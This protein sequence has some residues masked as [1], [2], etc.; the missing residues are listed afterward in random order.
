MSTPPA[1]TV[2]VA[3]VSSDTNVLKPSQATVQFFQGQTN[4]SVSFQG[5]AAGRVTV[6][7]TDPTGLYTPDTLIMGVLSTLEFRTIQSPTIRATN[8]S[9]NSAE[10]RSILVIL[11]DPAPPAGLAV[12]FQS[13]TAG[14]AA[15][16][17]ATAT[18]PGGQLSAQVDLTGTGGRLDQS[19]A[20][21]GG[22]CRTA[23]LG[24]HFQAQFGFYYFYSRSGPASTSTTMSR[25]RT[26]WI[27]AS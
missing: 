10:Q 15:S 19:H 27:G 18:I 21:G 14:I 25:C 1:G 4:S 20:G 23:E 8:F 22:L 6:T 26:R 13:S 2:T 3:I 12:D 9:I 24:E 11:S 17:P 7:A 16:P 5:R